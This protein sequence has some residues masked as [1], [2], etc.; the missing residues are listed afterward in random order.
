VRIFVVCGLF[1]L[2]AGCAQESKKPSGDK[3]MDVDIT[4][5]ITGQVVDFEE[6]TGRLD[7][8][9]TTDIRARVSGY[10]KDAPFKEGDEVHQGDV[11]FSI[12]DRTY[13][14]D[15]KQAE[16]TLKL[17]EA[18]SR[19]Q[20]K[21]ANRDKKLVGPRAVSQEDFE[22]AVATME[23]AKANVGAM[24]AARNRA[25]VY[26]EF[27]EVRAPWSGRISRRMVDPGNS[28]VADN[29]I[30]TTLVTEDPLYAYFDV[31]ERTYLNLVESSVS[32]ATS[33]TGSSDFPVV[34]R[35]ANEAEF[36]RVGKVNFVDN[37][38][39]AATGTIRM[40]GVFANPNKNLKPGLFARI[41]LPIGS[42]YE[43]I[44]VPDEAV[45]SD[46]DRKYVFVVD[47]NHKVVYRPVKIGQEIGGMRVIKDAVLQDGK[48]VEGV[49]MGEQVIIA[50][51][52]RV[53]EGNRVQANSQE[54]RKAPK[55]DLV[56]LLTQYLSKKN[57]DKE[58]KQTGKGITK[59]GAGS[60]QAAN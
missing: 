37:R 56:E 1:I 6:F 16:A 31:D 5:P 46:Q 23:K 30:L 21:I 27:T 38:V 59:P 53:R 22:T 2:I 43:A 28:V 44:L 12:D 7:A 9:K 8:L 60:A 19:L 40:R 34:L 35:L 50:G 36:S 18:D 4:K 41:R 20:E 42:P 57:G 15:L 14:A 26:E 52:Q 58:S 29:T 11:L 33:W 32:K 25:K 3:L 55:S 54:P 10:V 47:E 17:A 51:M 13:K 39:N 48:V 45:L 24:E 49:K